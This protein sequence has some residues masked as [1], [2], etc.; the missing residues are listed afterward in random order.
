[1]TKGE[2]HESMNA[3]IAQSEIDQKFAFYILELANQGHIPE[4][5]WGTWL[6]FKV[7]LIISKDGKALNMHFPH[8][9]PKADV[10]LLTG[11]K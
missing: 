9:E 4:D 10:L 1:M 2:F 6:S 11:K 3:L 7:D 5:W 8:L